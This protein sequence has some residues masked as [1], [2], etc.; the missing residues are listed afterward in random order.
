MPFSCFNIF[1]IVPSIHFLLS[2]ILLYINHIYVFWQLFHNDWCKALLLWI[3]LMLYVFAS[4][5]N[6]CFDYHKISVLSFFLHYILLHI[7]IWNIFFRQYVWIQSLS[8]Q[9]LVVSPIQNS[10]SINLL[11]KLIPN[12]CIYNI[13]VVLI[14]KIHV[15]EGKKPIGIRYTLF[16][17]LKW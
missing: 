17:E 1:I 13:F 11:D 16:K 6:I 15:F 2:C 4:M 7:G 3:S 8:L 10:H 14:S 12:I 9:S 5:W